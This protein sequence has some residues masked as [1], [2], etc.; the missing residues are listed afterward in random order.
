[1]KKIISSLFICLVFLSNAQTFDIIPLGVYGGGDESNLSSYLIGEKD[2]NEFLCLDAGTIRFGINKAIENKI[3]SVNSEKVLKNYIKG[4][5]IS[6]GHLDHLS[7][8][9]LNSPNDNSKNIYAINETIETLK[10]RYFTNDSWVNFANEGNKPMLGKYKYVKPNLSKEF[11]IEGTNLKGK[12]FE[13]SHVNP[14]KSSAIL[15]T[16]LKGNSVLY[17]GD[18]GADRIEKS[19]NLQNLWKNISSI[20]Q[21]KSLKAIMIEVSFENNHP[22]NALYGHLTPNL[23]IEEL[24]SLAKICNK[25]DLKNLKIIVTHMKPNEKNIENI[26]RQII[27]N[28]P[29]KVE[30]IFPKQGE[31][32]EL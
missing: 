16:N 2:K 11:F 28:N 1:M 22:E 14:Y 12:I 15:V 8:L 4:Y 29:L 25:K 3:F 26:K 24:S 13:L 23:L 20:V 18:T 19:N 30:F 31:K 7:G 27:S 32:I 6:H 9:I 17:L 10:N 21:N 5:F